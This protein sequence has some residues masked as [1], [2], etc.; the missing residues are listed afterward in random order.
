[1]K[2]LLCKV[3]SISLFPPGGMFLKYKNSF[4]TQNIHAF[5]YRNALQL[6]TKHSVLGTSCSFTFS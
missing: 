3:L 2:E 6:H 1:L 4:M 5:N